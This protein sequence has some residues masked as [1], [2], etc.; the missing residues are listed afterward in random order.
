MKLCEC[1]CGKEIIQK[2]NWYIPRFICGHGNKGRTKENDEGRKNQ[3]QKLIG[4]TRKNHEGRRKQ[5][6]W[7]KNGGASYISSF[8][9]K[10]G[11]KNQSKKMSKRRKE[12]YEYLRKHSERMRNGGASYAK[13]FITKEGRKRGIEKQVEKLTGRTKE[14]HEGIRRQSEK[15]SKY[16]KNG[17]AS[18]ACSYNINPSI[19]QVELWKLVS[20]ICPYVYL[21]FPV[22][23]PK[24]YSIDVAIPKLNIAIEFDGS[25]WHQDREKDSRRQKE[26]E[27]IGWKFIRYLD[28]IPSKEK[29][30][31]DI[32]S[33]LS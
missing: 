11:R 31:S 25:Y 24:C 9:S 19:P 28:K 10:E 2:Y 23:D 21:N 18:Y 26:L 20:K 22:Y 7:M 3:S 30:K 1:G 8:V 14:T 4:R 6:E 33:L 16:M 15:Q 29:V 5:S 27:E 13:S 32:L 17:G 12:N